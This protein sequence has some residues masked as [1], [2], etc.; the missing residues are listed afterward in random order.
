MTCDNLK[1][2]A[3]LKGIRV[4][5]ISFLSLSFESPSHE[6]LADMLK[7]FLRQTL[8]EDVCLLVA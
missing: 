5:A 8:G 2:K 7:G 3:N 4:G 6:Q 1:G